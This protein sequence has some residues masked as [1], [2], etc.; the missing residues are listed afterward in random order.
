LYVIHIYYSLCVCVVMW[1]QVSY[2][3]VLWQVLDFLEY[4]HECRYV[5]VRQ[6]W[7]ISPLPLHSMLLSL[8]SSRTRAFTSPDSSGQPSSLLRRIFSIRSQRLVQYYTA[9]VKV[10]VKQSH[11]RP[12]QTQRVPGGW[13]SQISRQLAH[14]GGKV[15]S[16]MYRPS[17]PP[18]NIPGTHFCWRLS[19]PQN[20]SAAGR[21]MSM[22]KIQWHHRESNLRP[23]GL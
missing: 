18:G 17:L 22:K 7:Y 2:S 5:C 11:Y 23:S 13:G 6:Y 3:V 19:Q 1:W 16:L 10:N 8:F 12:G 9:K 21:I 15:V 14:E 20:H 4:I